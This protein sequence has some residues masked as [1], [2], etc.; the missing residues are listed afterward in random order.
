M[1]NLLTCWWKTPALL[2]DLHSPVPAT[3]RGKHFCEIRVNFLCPFSTSTNLFYF[4]QRHY[5]VRVSKTDL[6]VPENHFEGKKSVWEK[7]F[8]TS[9]VSGFE[10]KLVGTLATTVRQPYQNCG[11]CAKET[12]WGIYCFENLY[13]TITF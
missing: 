11:L 2:S 5:F 13:N 7:C 10:Q 8:K 4:L 9:T 3:F 6:N 12:N 1:K